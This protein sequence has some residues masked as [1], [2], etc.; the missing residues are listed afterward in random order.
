MKKKMHIHFGI[1]RTGT[2]SIH[3]TLLKNKEALRKAGYLYPKLDVDYRHVKVAWGLISKKL[4]IEELVIKIDKE[5]KDFPGTI[6]L[7]SED[8]AQVKDLNWLE[9]LDEYYD[10]TGSIFLK[11]QDLWL[12]SWYNQHIKWPWNKKFSSSSIDFFLDNRDEFYWIDY[13][14]LLGSITSIID[15]DKLHVCVMERDLVPDVTRYFIENILMANTP[16]DYIQEANASLTKCKLDIVRSIDLISC[17]GSQRKNILA[18]VN[19]IEVKE[20]NGSKSIIDDR[21]RKEILAQFDKSNKYVASVYFNRDS[22]FNKDS[23]CNKLNKDLSSEA[24]IG[25]IGDVVKKLTK[26]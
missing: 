24:I 10:I 15:K 16:V 14:Y 11:R 3:R 5:A 19:A 6:I 9:Y 7:S 17:N 22:L 18:A 21:K 12:E 26:Q 13:K 1:H 25:Y 2:T 23:I 4:S 8:F 20:D